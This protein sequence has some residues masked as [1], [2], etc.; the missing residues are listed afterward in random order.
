MPEARLDAALIARAGGALVVRVVGGIVLGLAVAGLA[1][2]V[3]ESQGWLGTSG[4]RWL[5]LPF[6]GIIAA[7]T[8]GYSGW[9][10]GK[11]RA[12]EVVLIDSGV[13][14]RLVR[15]AVTGDPAKD[16]ADTGS[17]LVR[18]A[19]SLARRLIGV[20]MTQL[21]PGGDPVK[22]VTERVCEE[23]GDWGKVR[24]YLA[25]GVAAVVLAL[26]PALV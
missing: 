19:K 15:G 23:I 26:T 8:L 12:A 1:F 6:D 16:D 25:L 21:D 2:G 24:L 4:A 13:V 20:A 9:I 7:I 3:M 14:A 11:R 18:W 10:L 22:R 5:A 17:S